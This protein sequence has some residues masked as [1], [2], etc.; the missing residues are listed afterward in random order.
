MRGAAVVVMRDELEDEESEDHRGACAVDR[1]VDLVE[2]SATATHD[3]P[4]TMTSMVHTKSRAIG[5][6]PAARRPSAE[7]GLASS[8]GTSS[9][10][11]ATH[12]TPGNRAMTSPLSSREL[13]TD[14]PMRSFTVRPRPPYL[15]ISVRFLLY[16][17]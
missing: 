5:T 1:R 13:R 14:R 8:L 15:Y 12:V 2:V 3:G 4:M 6:D 7:G 17:F 11:A 10:A 9:Y 16:L